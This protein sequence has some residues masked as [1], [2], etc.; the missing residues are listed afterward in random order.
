MDLPQRETALF[1]TILKFYEHRQYKKGL[2]TAEQILK[3]FPNHGETLAMKGLFL[4]HLDRKEEAYD[5]VRKGLRNNLRSHICW[6]VFGL[7]YRSDKNYEEALKCYT[8]ALKYDKENL[9]ILRDYSLLHIQ[10]RNYEGF[11]DASHQLLELRPQNRAFWVSLAIAYHLMKNYDAA[12]NVLT[13]YEETLKEK[14]KGPDFENSELAMYKNMIIEESGDIEKA[15]EHLKEIEDVVCDRR[16]LKEKRAQFLLQLERLEE[17]EKVY[18]GLVDE[19]PDCRAYID[20][21]LA[22]RG[23]KKDNLS[24]NEDSQAIE[25]IQELIATYPRSNLLKRYPLSLVNGEQFKQQVAIYL[26]QQLR[27]GVPSLF[28]NLK[29]LYT[30]SEKVKIIED[31]LEG[32]LKNYLE[33]GKFTEDREDKE[34]P[35]AYLWTLYY[36]AQ[37]YDRTQQIEKALEYIDKAIEH[38]PTMVELYMTKGRILKHTGDF[39]AAAKCLNEGREL[40]LQDRC[41]NSKCTKYMLRNDQVS[42]AEKTITLFTRNDSTDPLSDL[43]DMQC[44]WFALESAE[45]SNTTIQVQKHFNEFTDDQFDFHTYCLRKTTI[46]AYVGLLRLEDQLRSHPYYFRAAQNA[47]KHYLYLHD[48]P[49][50]TQEEIDQANFANMT[51]SEIKKYKNK[52]RKAALKGQQ[53]AESK[54]AQAKDESHKNQVN[55]KVDEDPNGDKY[56]NSENPLR[57][58]LQFLIPLQELAGNRIE[59]HLQGFEIYLRQQKYL[60]ALKALKHAHRIDAQN[61]A[62]HKQIV[63]LQQAVSAAGEL[64]PVVRKVIDQEFAELYSR[65]TPLDK[66]NQ[67]FL[68]NN[69]GSVPALI[70]TSE[71]IYL[72]D[73]SKQSEAEA[74]LFQIANSEYEP[75]RTLKN[76]SAAYEALVQVLKSSRG[77][78]FKEMARKWFP[79]GKLFQSK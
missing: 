43:V 56:V 1:K 24:G 59:T 55:K 21:L 30:N 37:H 42:D 33:T 28:V 4:N 39:E 78:E 14:P 72:I 51:P 34:L 25:L 76:V 7:L 47:V 50:K 54:K 74:L 53:E 79:H 5:F 57:D 15:L 70:A 17:A 3:K 26:Q 44:M 45:R 73:S 35:T 8:H 32:Y 38:T 27:K 62:L 71:V 20:G 66:F 60:L 49:K 22:C 58:A 18:R 68:E 23:Y 6:H 65:D 52:Q 19:N 40:D 77:E 12:I 29:D 41:I 10:M 2:K 48:N 67:Q 75:T 31:L 64:H 63:R 9:Q 16:S 61:P 11:C 69:K 13:S 46:R 36:L